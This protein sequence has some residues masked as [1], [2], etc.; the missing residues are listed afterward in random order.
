MSNPQVQ[1]LRTTR[2]ARG[3]LGLSVSAQKAGPPRPAPIHD[4]GP[5]PVDM[6]PVDP[7][8]C[9]P[10]AAA[11]PLPPP[12]PAV[13]DPTADSTAEHP[14]AEHPTATDPGDVEPGEE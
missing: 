1:E 12:A 3:T 10:G 7:A 14:A 6:G 5:S 13:A 2:G 8:P 4:T 9:G 11:R